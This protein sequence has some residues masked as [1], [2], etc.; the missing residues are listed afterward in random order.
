[1]KY[2]Y[3]FPLMRQLAITPQVGWNYNFLSANAAQTGNTTYGDGA[4]SQA[5]TIGAKIV[6][7]PMQHLYFFV[8][9][10]YMFA[11]SKDNNFKTIENASNVS[12]D[13]FGVHV[14]LLVNF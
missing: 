5:L 12:A 13:G 6:L 2:G 3:Q 4:S 7:V 10:E 11:L 8:A 9:P 14:G 1:V